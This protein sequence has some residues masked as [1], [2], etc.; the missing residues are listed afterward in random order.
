[1]TQKEKSYYPSTD[2]I[3]E[4]LEREDDVREWLSELTERQRTAVEL[5]AELDNQGEVAEVM[6]ISQAAVSQLLSGARRKYLKIT[7]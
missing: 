1:M 2:R 4:A 6:G 5:M 3:A 7:R